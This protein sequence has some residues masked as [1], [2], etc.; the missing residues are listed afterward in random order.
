MKIKKYLESFNESDANEK[1]E[2]HR[3]GLI[4]LYENQ[5]EEAGTFMS[6]VLK[7][8]IRKLKETKLNPKKVEDWV[9]KLEKTWIN[10]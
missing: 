3:K 4:E 6:I 9:I 8:A 2:I 5:L 7:E 10:F 1:I